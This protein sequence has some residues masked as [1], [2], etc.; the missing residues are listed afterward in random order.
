MNATNLK[1]RSDAL[2]YVAQVNA[3]DELSP[4]K[5]GHDACALWP[6]GRCF[7]HALS[8]AERICPICGNGDTQYTNDAGH[9]GIFR[10]R[11]GHQWEPNE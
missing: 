3:A 10:C 7:D 1:W 2:A 11:C 8:R 4:C 6:A 5:N 9:G